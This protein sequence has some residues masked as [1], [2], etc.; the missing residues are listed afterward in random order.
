VYGGPPRS[1]LGLCRGLQHAEAQVAVVTTSAN[2]AG[3]LP[4]DVIARSTFEGVPVSYLHRGFPRRHFAAPGLRT[5]LDAHG[6]DYDLIHVHGCW[7]LFGWSAAGWCRK[8]GVPYVLSPRGMLHPSSFHGS[9]RK[10]VA[11]NVIDRRTLKA[12]RFIHATSA[13]ESEIVSALNIGSRILMVPNGVDVPEPASGAEMLSFRRRNGACAADFVLLSLGRLH[14]Q[15]GLD[16]LI[17]AFRDLL[18]VHPRAMLWLAGAGESAYVAKLRDMT[19][20]LQQAGRV[21]FP[22]FLEGDDRRLALASAD[23]FVLTSHSENFGMGVAEAMAAGRPVVVSRGCPWGQIEEWRA[24][25]HVDNAPSAIADAIGRLIT[26]PAAARLMGEN[27][28]RAVRQTLDWNVLA[29]TMLEAYRSIL[30]PA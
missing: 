18:Q 19:R 24:G 13:E 10:T 20:D 5:W 26:D 14:A 15:K 27:G 23:A 2:G 28:R 22:G 21:T 8:A 7:N 6:R 29:A 11:Y 17:D 1:V 16:I 30:S 12:A 25:F 4:P 9:I 3:E